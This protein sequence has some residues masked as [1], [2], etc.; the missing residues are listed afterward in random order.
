MTAT[1]SLYTVTSVFVAAERD[2]LGGTQA[3][4]PTNKQ[5][6]RFAE[7][8]LDPCRAELA[9]ISELSS[10][11]AL[12]E[13]PINA[14]LQKKGFDIRLRAFPKLVPPERA[15]GAASVLDVLLQWK[16]KGTTTTVTAQKG[17]REFPAAYISDKEVEI[18]TSQKH[19]NPIACLFTKT[20]DKVLMTV[21]EDQLEHLDLVARAKEIS[22]RKLPN[23]SYRGLVFPMVDLNHRV[24]L[25][26][27]E[28]M[29]ALDSE[30]LFQ[31]EITQ[32]LQQTRLKMNHEGVR[33]KD[34]VA[35]G[36]TMLIGSSRADPPLVI[37]RPFLF[38]IERRGLSNP[39]FV[40]RIT[41]ECW[42]DP[43][44]LAM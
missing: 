42:K 30:G 36:G 35:F 21:C 11:A 37:N 9:H 15:W 7:T 22:L 20:G 4:N 26:W 44:S 34:A 6:E 40:A 18:F 16:K 43:G 5:Q 41:E 17:K 10:I 25:G 24:D 28:G 2:I 12:S 19:P 3:W 27:L 14:F 8:F 33:V 13:R 1:A 31:N 39:L 29:W 38:W 32:A 23:F